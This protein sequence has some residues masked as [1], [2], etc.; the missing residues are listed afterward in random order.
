L[1][2]RTVS[3]ELKFKSSAQVPGDGNF[4]QV[5]RPPRLALTRFG[6]QA[7]LFSAQL[8][9]LNARLRGFAHDLQSYILCGGAKV[10]IIVH[11]NRMDP[12]EMDDRLAHL[13]AEKTARLLRDLGRIERRL[14]SVE[15]I[16]LGAI[17]RSKLN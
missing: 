12:D 9:Y 5:H 10:L 4:L 7:Q 17:E 1:P 15:A 8:I 3:A 6:G 2:H 16:I 13:V 14:V 11:E